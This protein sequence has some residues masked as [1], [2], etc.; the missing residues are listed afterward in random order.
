MSFSDAIAVLDHDQSALIPDRR[1]L[2]AAVWMNLANARASETAVES[3]T[4]ARD[5]AR[6]AMALV[7]DLEG[8]D[9]DAAEVGLR[10]RHV[11][12]RTLSTSLSAVN[13][14]QTMPDDVHEATD[15]VDDGLTLVRQWE[16]R[17]V[18]RF[19]TVAYDLFRFGAR[20]YGR[21]QP[22]FLN[23]FVFD[24]IDPGQSSPDYVESGEMRFAA[25]EALVFA[26]GASG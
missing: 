25:M 14:Q 26:R 18:A 16:Q 11:L 12:C 3:G 13:P 4:L 22:Q 2:L 5:A 19:R 20:V 17:G 7:A 15:I 21:Y 6:R 10:A 9:A 8:D 1:Y 24:N 23:E